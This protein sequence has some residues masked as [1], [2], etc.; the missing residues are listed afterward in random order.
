MIINSGKGRIQDYFGKH[1]EDDEHEHRGG[2]DTFYLL[3][4]WIFWSAAAFI[5]SFPENFYF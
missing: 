1:N 3:P 5:S 4:L 2:H